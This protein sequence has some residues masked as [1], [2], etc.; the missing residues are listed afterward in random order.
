MNNKILFMIY[1]GEIKFLQNENM[2]HK[3]WFISLGGKL[4]D[5]DNTIRGFIMENK[6][7]FFKAN[8]SYDQEVIKMASACA[9]IMKEQL[10]NP[11]LTVWCGITPGQNGAKW[12][13]IMELKE[14]ELTGFKDNKEEVNEG[15][16]LEF[17]EAEREIVEFKNDY[18]D[19]K[20]I[21]LAT[22]FTIV[23]IA[24]TIVSKIILVLLKKLDFN[25]GWNKLLVLAQ[26]V[27]LILTLIGYQ[28]KNPKAKFYGLIA[29]LSLV[30]MFEIPDIIIA[31]INLL[32][33]LDQGY[34]L[35][36]IE[37][38]R[39]GVDKS[40]NAINKIKEKK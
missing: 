15:F 35:K 22:K 24:L 30:F 32:F 14:E 8:L 12:E 38:S 28:K 37:M 1:N 16:K 21:K 2:D 10:K 29:S 23:M 20:F 26:V 7:I 40:K 17:N 39:Q 11:T 27:L 34:I 13:P 5:Y 33:T 4:E 6:I 19:P 9:P 3:E 31:I 36:A 18:E 25:T